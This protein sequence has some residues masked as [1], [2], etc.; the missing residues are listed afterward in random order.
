MD[1]PQVDWQQIT[2]LVLLCISE[3]LALIPAVKVKSG[4][5]IDLIINVLKAMQKKEDP[6]ITP[7]G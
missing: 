6:S 2:L 1:T 4:G 3:V 7:K 5:I